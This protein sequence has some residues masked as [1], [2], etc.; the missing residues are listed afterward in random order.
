[1]SYSDILNLEQQTAAAYD[2]MSGN[3]AFADSLLKTV[4]GEID[5]RRKLKETIAEEKRKEESTIRINKEKGLTTGAYY[6]KIIDPETE[7]VTYKPIPGLQTGSKK[8]IIAPSLSKQIIEVDSKTGT[9]RIMDTVPTNARIAI[10]Q[11]SDEDIKSEAAARYSG[12][13]ETISELGIIPPGQAGMAALASQAKDVYIPELKKILFPDGTPKSFRRGIAM[14]SSLPVTDSPMPFN[15]D[16]QR[17]YRFMY[18]SLSAKILIQTGV[19]AREEEVKAEM[20][21]FWN[22]WGSDAEA[23][24]EGFSHLQGFYNNYLSTLSSRRIQPGSIEE[25]KDEQPV[26][27]TPTARTQQPPQQRTTQKPQKQS[28]KSQYNLE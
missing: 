7:E 25:Q 15:E 11:K 23:A 22:D 4:F 12:I 17:V 18:D 8:D 14:S 20:N 26:T 16:A 6:E 28:I 19:A 27:S 24:Y 10:K 5:R 9:S 2:P 1:M 3:R 13:Q 21:K